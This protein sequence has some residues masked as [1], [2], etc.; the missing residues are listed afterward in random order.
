MHAADSHSAGRIECRHWRGPHVLPA[1]H[2]EPTPYVGD[3]LLSDLIRETDAGKLTEAELLAN[4]WGLF[5][6]GFDTTAAATLNAILTLT[7]HPDQ[8]QLLKNDWSLLSTA[9]E[10]C[11]RYDGPGGGALRIFNEE[12]ELEGVMVPP[13]T[14]VVAYKQSSN[15]D[16]EWLPDAAEFNILRQPV[17]HLSFGEGVHKCLGLHL[18]KVTIGVA[19]QALFSR[20]NNVQV[21]PDGVGWEFDALPLRNP[22]R[23]QVEWESCNPNLDASPYSTRRVD[24]H[25]SSGFSEQE[26]TA[27]Q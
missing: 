5:A 16:P 17:Q 26:R 9:V 13:G 6:G 7:N 20:L 27:D 2:R 18:A 23:L 21:A 19:V 12:M 11:L 8:L 15:L 24:D 25:G 3:D 10:E 4:T 14:P 1:A 22:D